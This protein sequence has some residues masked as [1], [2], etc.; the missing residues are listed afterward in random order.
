MQVRN[1][2]HAARWNKG[3]KK[4]AKNRHLGTIAQICRAISSQLRHVSTIGKTLVKQRYLLHMSSQYGELRPTNGWDRL[5]SL[6]HPCKF[7]LVSRLDN[8]TAQHLVVGVSQTLRRWTE[9][10]TCIRQSDHHVGHWPTFLADSTFALL[11]KMDLRFRGSFLRFHS[12]AEDSPTKLFDG[13]QMANSWRFFAP[14]FSASRVQHV[15]DLHPK[16]AL[17]PHIV[18]GSMVDIQFP[19]A[20]NGRGNKKERTNY[21]A[22]YNGLP[23]SIGRP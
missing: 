1:V 9:G 18:C 11:L 8:V 17:R 21:R 16:F 14:A 2:L 7:Q 19:T 4:V 13:A 3:H 10:A 5:N 6:G 20:E 12:M 15:S 22:K 23:Y